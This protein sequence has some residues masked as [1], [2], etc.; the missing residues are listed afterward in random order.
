MVGHPTQGRT[1]QWVPGAYFRWATP[2][3]DTRVVGPGLGW[4]T[5]GKGVYEGD[6][7][8]RILFGAFG[9]GWE[10]GRRYVTVF[11]VKVDRGPAPGPATQ[12]RQKLK[13]LPEKRTSRRAARAERRAARAEL[14]RGRRT[15]R[16]RLRAERRAARAAPGRGQARR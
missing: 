1:F 6:R 4:W 9:A 2:E 14:R 13:P 12:P 10:G 5:K 15:A 11:G 7:S 8:W 16:A 3:K